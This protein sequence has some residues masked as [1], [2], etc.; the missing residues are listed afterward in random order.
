MGFKDKDGKLCFQAVQAIMTLNPVFYFMEN[1]LNLGNAGSDGGSESD[2][3]SIVED[4][5]ARLPKY[6]HLLLQG[7]DPSCQGYPTH[8]PRLALI[9]GR[10][11][12]VNDRRMVQATSNTP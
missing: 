3:T 8:R 4:L 9:G 2:L 10:K 5:R 1:V 6:H 7:L 12:Q 11:D